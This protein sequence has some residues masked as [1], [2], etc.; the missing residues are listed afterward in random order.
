M[1]QLAVRDQLKS[2]LPSRIMDVKHIKKFLPILWHCV[3]VYKTV[4]ENYMN[5]MIREDES[6]MFVAIRNTL[7][8]VF[9]V[10]PCIRISLQM[11]YINVVGNSIYCKIL[12]DFIYA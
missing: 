4:L 11:S 2:I 9:V 8:W 6:S 3:N 5:Q 1:V 7:Y 10:I 12:M